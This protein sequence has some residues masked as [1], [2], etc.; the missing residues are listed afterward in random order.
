M[1]TSFE[2]PPTGRDRYIKGGLMPPNASYFGQ[3]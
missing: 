2:L 1:P 3:K